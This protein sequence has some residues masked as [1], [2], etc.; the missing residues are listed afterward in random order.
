ML[1]E[2]KIWIQS[3]FV[4]LWLNYIR[5]GRSQLSLRFPIVHFVIAWELK[6]A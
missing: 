6:I 4:E 1:T 2:I 3:Q 5:H